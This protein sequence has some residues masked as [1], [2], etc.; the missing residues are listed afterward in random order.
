MSQRSALSPTSGPSAGHLMSE[1]GGAPEHLAMKAMGLQGELQGLGDRD[2]TLGER[3]DVTHA[4]TQ[5]KA[6]G[7]LRS[8]G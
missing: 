1:G 8:H 5:G 4:E 7:L 2:S 6:L 3:T